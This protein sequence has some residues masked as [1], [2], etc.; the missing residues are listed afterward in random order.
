MEDKGKSLSVQIMELLKPILPKNVGFIMVVGDP[1]TADIGITS[2]MSDE[3][4]LAFLESAA[5]SITSDPPIILDGEAPTGQ[6]KN[7]IN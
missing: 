4:A 5:I 6:D 7:S 2:N 3:L 1:V